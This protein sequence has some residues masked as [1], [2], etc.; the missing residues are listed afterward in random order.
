V[1]GPYPPIILPTSG[2]LSA[3]LSD[4]SHAPFLPSVSCFL[5]W[6]RLARHHLAGVGLSSWPL[7]AASRASD[8]PSHR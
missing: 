3:P 2:H 5:A 7:P 6:R 1:K 8:G 4:L